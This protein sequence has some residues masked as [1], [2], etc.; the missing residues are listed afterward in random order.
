M[1]MRSILYSV[2]CTAELGF[3]DPRSSR[4]VKNISNDLFLRASALRFAVYTEQAQK[5]CAR[6]GARY[7]MSSCAVV[8]LTVSHAVYD[9]WSFPDA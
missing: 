5:G 7:R 1:L 2:A 3:R 6:F 4:G 8:Q 9:S